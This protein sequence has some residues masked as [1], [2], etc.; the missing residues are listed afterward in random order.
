V[1]APPPATTD[2]VKLTTVP[3]LTLVTALPPEVTVSWV[4]LTVGV[5]AHT[6]DGAQEIAIVIARTTKR[7]E[8]LHAKPLSEKLA[9]EQEK[10]ERDMMTSSSVRGVSE[11]LSRDL[12]A[13]NDT[14]TKAQML[15][16]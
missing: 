12:T 5:C 13:V 16:I 15:Y 14:S 7:T 2:A 9:V 1:T 8:R 11:A 3:E 10:H 6:L 4:V